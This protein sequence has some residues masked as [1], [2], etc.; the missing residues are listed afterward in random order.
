M[1][2]SFSDIALVRSSG[3]LLTNVIKENSDLIRKDSV[4][5]VNT[6]MNI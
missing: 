6:S 3:G 5:R 2:A 4:K 1:V